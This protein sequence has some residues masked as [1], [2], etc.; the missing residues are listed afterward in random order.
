[1]S[2]EVVTDGRLL[3][4]ELASRLLAQNVDF[5]ITKPDSNDAPLF[6]GRGPYSLS[7]KGVVDHLTQKRACIHLKR[8][9]ERN[10][11]HLLTHI[12]LD[13]AQYPGADTVALSLGASDDL[14]ED[15]LPGAQTAL[16]ELADHVKTHA[17]NDHAAWI[18]LLE[19]PM[20]EVFNQ[21]TFLYH[22]GVGVRSLVV[23][24]NGAL[25]AE[26]ENA[27]Y[28]GDV[29]TGIDRGRQKA[30]I[31]ST[32]IEAL[33]GCASCWVRHLCG[34]ACRVELK[35]KTALDPVACQLKRRTY[36]LAMDAC[37]DIAVHHADRLHRRYGD[38]N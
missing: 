21:N 27:F 28:M 23:A 18:S 3:N 16:E 17:M 15:D 13:L 30:W 29:Q 36:E 7:S 5:T 2:F 6:L 34:G 10:R 32:H 22:S 38:A 11:L 14:T 24:P 8:V 33:P 25:Y 12:A 26:A 4:A 1:L 19:D 20:V 9:V 37:L 31:R 35:D